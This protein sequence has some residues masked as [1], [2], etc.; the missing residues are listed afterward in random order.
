MP[1]SD[2]EC[3][4]D[5]GYYGAGCE[6]MHHL[7]DAETSGSGFG[8][9]PGSGA[10]TVEPLWRTSV[11]GFIQGRGDDEEEAAEGDLLASR[12]VR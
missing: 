12:E 9:P 11:P 10:S 1:A 5:A 3:A 7:V 8:P 2:Y 6:R 4:C